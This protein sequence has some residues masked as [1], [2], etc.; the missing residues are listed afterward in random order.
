[1]YRG[2]GVV[3][4]AFAVMFLGFG[5]AY[6]FTTF[7][8]ELQREFSASHASISFIFSLAGF[9]YFGIGAGSGM[10]ADRMGPRWIS[11][12]GMV[13]LGAGLA[14]ASV[15]ETI[16]IVYAG[17]GLGI[18]VGVGL[19]YVPSIGAVQP[20]F[21]LKRGLASGIAVSGI[22][23]GTLLGPIVAAAAIPA[24]GWRQTLLVMGL[25]AMVGGIVASLFLD[26]D[27]KGASEPG[28]PSASGGTAPSADG[29][30]LP[31]ALRSRPFWLLYVSSVFLSI[32]MF[33]P[34][35]HI[36]PYALDQGFEAKVGAYVLGAIGIGSTVGRFAVGGL[37][38][39]MGRENALLVAYLG[40][41][42][43][44]VLWLAG[45]SVWSLYI[46]ALIFGACY[47]GFVAL[48]P[49]VC[50]DYFGVRAASSIIGVLYTSVAF[51]TLIGPTFAGAVYDHAG[52]YAG[53]ILFGELMTAIAV[54]LVVLLP[55]PERWRA[56]RGPK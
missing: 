18:G 27:P 2:W 3:A 45:G 31:E 19:S 46:F 56:A 40:V 28:A 7:F 12:T 49:A 34:F 17:F 48:A 11:V 50:T 39:R 15:A 43:M 36:V 52:D 13:A 16:W 20:W 5:C 23:L 9:L 26:N 4:A 30:S 10:L 32:G 47:G 1:M 55:K 22:G 54:V 8:P 41:T 38:D 33:I 51:G 42:A 53:A 25:V 35:V 6:S 24:F 21:V 29:L 37:A 44:Q 14:L